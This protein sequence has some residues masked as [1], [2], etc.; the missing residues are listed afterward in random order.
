MERSV[1]NA[2]NMHDTFELQLYSQVIMLATLGNEILSTR[3]LYTENILLTAHF[4]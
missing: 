3:K 1:H 4:V 2:S